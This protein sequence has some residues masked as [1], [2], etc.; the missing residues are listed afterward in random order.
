MMSTM[1]SFAQ[2]SKLRS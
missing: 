2:L 1:T